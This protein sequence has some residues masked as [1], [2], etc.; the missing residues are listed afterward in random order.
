MLALEG[1]MN[2]T[3]ACIVDYPLAH[4]PRKT[5]VRKVWS[6]DGDTHAAG[7]L[8]TVLGSV[9]RPDVGVAYFISCDKH[10]RLPTF[11]IDAKL[12]RE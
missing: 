11:I 4:F 2:G 1:M 7:E 5:R 10:P 3:A 8:G 6:E 9:G 12:E